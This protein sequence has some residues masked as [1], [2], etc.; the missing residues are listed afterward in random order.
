MLAAQLLSS[1][2]AKACGNR[3]VRH[4][5]L[6]SFSTKTIHVVKRAGSERKEKGGG[7]EQARRCIVPSETRVSTLG[8]VVLN[9]WLHVRW[10]TVEGVGGRQGSAGRLAQRS[11]KRGAGEETSGLA[12]LQKGE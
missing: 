3:V 6:S 7:W 11:E 5:S 2:R 10:A 8:V 4:A 12:E 1:P 9:V